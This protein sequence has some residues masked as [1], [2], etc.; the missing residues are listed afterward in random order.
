MRFKAQFNYFLKDIIENVLFRSKNS[1][2]YNLSDTKLN[3]EVK[4]P[5]VKL[6]IVV[7]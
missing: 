2:L 7:H 5:K 4:E 1:V 3:S 6:E